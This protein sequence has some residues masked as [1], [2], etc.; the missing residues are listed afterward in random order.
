MFHYAF[1]EG[2]DRLPPG[3]VPKLHFIRVEPGVSFDVLGER[4]LP[5]RLEH[6][7]FPVLGYRVGPLAYCT[8]VS[9]IPESSL[10]ML[11]GLDVLVLDALR[12]DPHP[13]HFS[14]S[15]ALA[16]AASLKP[17]R[18][19]LTHLSHTFDHGPTQAVL[20]ASV[21]LAYDGLSVEF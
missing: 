10:A 13:T 7:P 21:S 3:V 11:E 6:G 17:R 12:Y 5:I 14:L 2:M 4:V 1:R 20:P 19:F 9:R 8:D 15:E 18:T 16:V